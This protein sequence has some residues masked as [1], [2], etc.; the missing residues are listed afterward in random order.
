MKSRIVKLLLILT[1]MLGGLV[2]SEPL[3]VRA[4][5]VGV[6]TISF[7][8]IRQTDIQL[9]GPYD[10]EVLAFGLPAEW[11]L[12]G[13]SEINLDINVALS[14]VSGVVVN[15]Q[16]IGVGGTLSVEYNREVVGSF[17]LTQNGQ[18]T[19]KISIPLALTK[20]VREDGRQEL[21][22]ELDSGFSC[23]V[24]QQ[25][26][27]TI[28]TSS[29]KVFPHED[30]LPDISLARFPFPIY[31]GSVNPDSALIVVPDKPTAEE[32]QSAMIVAGGLGK[33]TNLRLA[34]DL[35]RISDLT[36]GLLASENLILV[37]RASSLS[38]LEKLLLPLPSTSEGFQLQDMDDGVVELVQSPWKAG[39]VVLL[40]SGNSDVGVLKASQAVSTGVLRPNSNT[41]LAIIQNVQTELL[42]MG[43]KSDSTL[44]DLGYGTALLEKRGLD[45]VTY[46]FYIPP[47]MTLGPDAYFELFFG[48]SA[49]L[50]FTRSGLVV[51]VNNQPIGSARFSDVTAA[52][53]MNRLQLKIPSSIILSG[54]NTLEVISNLQPIDNCSLPNLRGLWA[55]IWSDS[56]L[57]L[58]LVPTLTQSNQVLSLIDYP[59]PF[60]FDPSLATTAFVLQPDDLESWRSAVQVA[61]Y[62]GDQADGSIVSF[63]T[64]YAD[65]IPD[66]ARSSLHFIVMGLAPQMAVITE[67]NNFLPAP[68]ETGAGIA[69]EKNMQVTFRIPAES[70]V[71]YVE[72]FSSPWNEGNVIIAAM[73]NLRQGT[74]WAISALY[75]TSLRSKLAG[76]FA[77]I[78][79]Q[80]VTTTDTRI[81]LPQ[82]VV[83]T[84]DSQDLVIIPPS[85]AE[86][87]PFASERPVWILPTLIAASSLIILILLS[88]AIQMAGISR[89][90]KKPA[91]AQV[92]DKNE[93][94]GED[95]SAS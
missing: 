36:P 47:G 81:S 91:S 90:Q 42:G 13:A 57:H 23:L 94:K 84:S 5:D 18:I 43:Q 6:D 82:E 64:Y 83:S 79:D 72:L 1:I 16:A 35:T 92:V 9:L 46:R 54:N 88:V 24:N 12:T 68:F 75:T 69:S 37:G 7:Y 95:E 71:G 26:T 41:N 61:A 58:P 67:L 21:V 78:N 65:A 52:N 22:F 86:T 87:S 44:A 59:A 76:N 53:S 4:Q 8:Q 77:V 50:D 45:S 80:Q 29:S 25:M 66:L 30:V 27:V 51:Q 85:A 62:L 3:Y 19:Q 14:S 15:D 31:Q 48:N 32:L 38:N 2:T 40:I 73:G 93:D 49:L 33:I 70:P 60:I 89:K 39:K 17:S 55:N 34:L 11:K 74:T 20:P 10:V 63:K 28:R 56:R